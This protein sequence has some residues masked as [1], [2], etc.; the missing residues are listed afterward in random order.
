MKVIDL[1]I[2]IYAINKDAPNHQQ[3]RKWWEN[4]LAE[5]EAIGLPW[6]VLLG[7]IRI[8]TNPRV[9]TNPLSP[10][11]ATALIDD[12]LKQP[13]VEIISPTERHWEILKKL[14][15]QLG[16]AS[17]LTT[18]AHIAALAIE[19]GGVLFSTDNDFSRFEHLKWENPLRF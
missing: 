7:F 17:N 11:D 1:N 14:I 5:I 9:F 3:A 15:L 18:D 4:C 13:S 6:I 8:T 10:E 2:L 16:T 12:W 19:N